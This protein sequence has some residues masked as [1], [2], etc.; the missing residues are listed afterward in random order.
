MG[1]MKKVHSESVKAPRDLGK[2]W[3]E[4]ATMERVVT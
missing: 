4:E 3:E 1:K 2:Y